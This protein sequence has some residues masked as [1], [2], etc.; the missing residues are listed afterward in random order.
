MLVIISMENSNLYATSPAILG[1]AR[2]S[3]GTAL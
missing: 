3:P 1:G 2:L